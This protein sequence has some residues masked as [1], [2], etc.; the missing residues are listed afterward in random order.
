[1]A[2]E[3]RIKSLIAELGS[4]DGMVRVRARKALADIGHPAVG[5]LVEALSSRR[6][7]LRWE[8]AKTLAEIG[9]PT[10]TQAL[11]KALRDKMFDVR[12]LAA[13]GLIHIGD[14]VV[15]PLLEALSND[16]DSLWMREGTH[17]VLHDLVPGCKD[18]ELLKPVLRALDDIEPSLEVEVAAG[19]ALEA[20]K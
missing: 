10:A 12:W 3:D 16:P 17:H 4:E 7:W 14:S 15:K 2:E 11:I 18:E 9:D 13:E 19:A 1:M 6:E 5:P 8:A 20:L